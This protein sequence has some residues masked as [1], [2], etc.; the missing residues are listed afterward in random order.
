MTCTLFSVRKLSVLTGEVPEQHDGDEGDAVFSRSLCKQIGGVRHVASPACRRPARLPAAG[1]PFRRRSPRSRRGPSDRA[2]L[3]RQARRLL[4]RVVTLEAARG[5]EEQP[6]RPRVEE[7]EAG[8]RLRRRHDTARE[9]PEVQVPTG[10]KPCRYGC[11]SIVKS[12]TP[13]ATSSTVIGNRSYRRT[14]GGRCRGR[15]RCCTAWPTAWVLPASTANIPAA[16]LLPRYHAS[17]LLSSSVSSAPSR[18]ARIRC[19]APD[20]RI[21]SSAPSIRGWMLSCP[22]VAMNSPTLPE[23]TRSTIR[24]PI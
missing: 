17:T 5:L 4:L 24:F 3:S 6:G 9:L 18:P 2:A 16:S 13:S 8:V 23:P 1:P 15:S 21:A 12:S 22:G 14:P 19:S 11:W 20:S 10:R 7:H